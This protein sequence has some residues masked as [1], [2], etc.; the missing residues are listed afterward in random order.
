MN[1][2]LERTNQVRFFTNMLEVLSALGIRGADYDWYVSDVE[3]N[4]YPFEEGWCS[5]EELESKIAA[6]NIQFIWAVFSAFP[7]G[8][9]VDVNGAPYVEGNPKYW[10]G[11]DP[12][13]QLSGAN[14]EIACWDSSATI[15]IGLT[16]E[17]AE[18]FKSTYS[19]AVS[20]SLAARQ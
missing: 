11:T 1:L 10:D 13:P 9:R 16:S 12:G 8:V 20:L 14:F 5:G 15:L 2:I 19:D 18:S 3:T 7:R 17:L 6:D 4:G